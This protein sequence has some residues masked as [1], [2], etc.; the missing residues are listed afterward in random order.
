MDEKTQL[1]W[2]KYKHEIETHRVYLDLAIKLNASYYAI[3]G[4][5][6]SFYFLH[7]KEHPELRWSLLLPILMSFVLAIFC[8][9]SG[10]SAKITQKDLENLASSLNF[11]VYS[12]IG[13]VLAFLL[14]IFFVLLVICFL[15]LVAVTFKDNILEIIGCINVR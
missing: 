10:R 2:E 3:T 11:E 6:V 7:I 8:Y 4:A 9:Q 5:I 15:G 1:L 13:N 12:A 14:N